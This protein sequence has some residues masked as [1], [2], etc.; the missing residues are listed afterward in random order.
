MYDH[1]STLEVVCV[2]FVEP[3]QLI[4]CEVRNSKSFGTH[5]ERLME[6]N[7]LRLWFGARAACGCRNICYKLVMGHMHRFSLLMHGACAVK[8]G[9]SSKPR[10]GLMATLWLSPCLRDHCSWGYPDRSGCPASPV[11]CFLTG[12][13]WHP[14]RASALQPT[15]L[16]EAEANDQGTSDTSSSPPLLLLLSIIL[17]LL[18]LFCHLMP[19]LCSCAHVR[20]APGVEICAGAYSCMR[21][22]AARFQRLPGWVFIPLAALPGERFLALTPPPARSE[23]SHLRRANGCVRTHSNVGSVCT[24]RCLEPGTSPAF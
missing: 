5:R 13:W 4:E 16:T 14:E 9:I 23:T 19:F 15:R 6:N 21:Y 1:Q 10:E 8:A 11:V 24:A 22:L 20:G 2:P 3:H 12:L 17:L 18:L 7:M